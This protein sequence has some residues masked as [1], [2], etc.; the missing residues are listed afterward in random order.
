MLNTMTNLLEMT[1]IKKPPSGGDRIQWRL[2]VVMADR[3]LGVNELAALTDMHYTSIS[4]LRK[5]LGAHLAL[6]T[7]EKLCVALDCQPGDLL[8]LK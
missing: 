2:A 5:G 7:L 6:E 1:P 3:Q 8:T 4:R